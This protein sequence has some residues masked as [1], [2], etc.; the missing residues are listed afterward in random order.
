M[1]L[2]Q[3][4]AHAKRYLIC[5]LEVYRSILFQH[6]VSKVDVAVYPR[7]GV[8]FLLHSCVSQLQARSI[9][10]VDAQR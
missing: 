9:E 2:Y 1:I 3:Q 6:Q 4:Y 8:I 5:V 10:F 7:A